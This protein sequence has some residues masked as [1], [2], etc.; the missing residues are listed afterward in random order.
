MR[1][2][3]A[4][5]LSPLLA[6]AVLAGC[7]V[8]P[9]YQRPE[10]TSP[11]RFYGQAAAAQA[12]SLADLP[13]W[14]V[15][16]DS[17]LQSLIQEALRDG[18]DV[19]IA[20]ARVAE[21]R[22]RWGIAGA[23]FYPQVSYQGEFARERFS[24]YQPGVPSNGAVSDLVSATVPN[25]SW[26]IDIWGR[27]RR[28]NESAKAQYFATEE[29][30]RGV[31]LTLVSEVAAAYF[32]LRQLDENLEIARRTTAEFQDTYNLFNAQ[33]QGGIASALDTADAEAAWANEAAQ[34]PLIESQIAAKENQLAAL[35]G[36]NPGPMPRG[37]PLFQQ[38][39]PPEI[40]PGLPAALLLRRP[41]LRQSEQQLISAN[42]N[43]GVAEAAFYPTISLTGM[44]GG[45]SPDLAHLFTKG[46]T[47]SIGA[48]ITGPIFEGG[49]L[50]AQYNVAKAQFDQARLRYEQQVNNALGEVSTS[51]VALG[52]LAD[53]TVQRQRGVHAYQE[54]VRLATLRY[55]SGLSAYFEVIDAQEN[56]LTSENSLAQTQH[57][58]LI[59]LVNLYKA[60]GGGWQ[61]EEKSAPP[62]ATAAAAAG[63]ASG[64][65]TGT[66]GTAGPGGAPEA[67]APATPQD[68]T[69][70]AQAPPPAPAEPSTTPPPPSSA[71]P[72]AADARDHR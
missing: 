60:L 58:R 43:I 21:A 31:V 56:L 38:P 29:A 45:L 57:D 28:L 34:V 16:Q 52:K 44:F 54:A 24:G 49:S 25:V 4:R 63:S 10:I 26:E 13:W 41:D 39:F 18:Y 42:A 35:L 8:G 20:A 27:V 67:S 15:F 23:A 37:T 2:P 70:A 66:A 9:T 1:A 46:E 14:Q 36:R 22:A 68:A 30:R 40:P 71:P 32:D 55:T 65:E 50:R 61:V 5:F 17:A 12:A 6:T 53:A 51:L 11:D 69:P 33:L 62:P 64:S 3:R 47:W 48:G 59:S 7:T 72:G 19:K